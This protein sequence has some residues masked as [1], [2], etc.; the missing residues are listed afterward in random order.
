MSF[1]LDIKTA[2]EIAAEQ[3]KEK[4]KA[5][6]AERDKLLTEC[7]WLVIREQDIGTPIPHEWKAYRQA[8]RDITDQLDFPDDVSW[9]ISP[10]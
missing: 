6:R 4:A 2:E 3:A 9:P 7:D 10:T 5:I 8:L 1:A